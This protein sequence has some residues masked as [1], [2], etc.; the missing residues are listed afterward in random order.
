M[1]DFK[2]HRV[3]AT[4]YVVSAFITKQSAENPYQFDGWFKNEADFR[5]F[6]ENGIK[7]LT[8]HPTRTIRDNAARPWLDIR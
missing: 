4:E 6:L 1:G 3:S 8:R 7:T 2:A 5:G